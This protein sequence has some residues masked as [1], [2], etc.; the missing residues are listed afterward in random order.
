MT[1]TRQTDTVYMLPYDPAGL[2]DDVATRS[3]GLGQAIGA[4]IVA[5]TV[6]PPTRATRGRIV[7]RT[8]APLEVSLHD[9]MAALRPFVRSPDSP[10]TEADIV[11]VIPPGGSVAVPVEREKTYYDTGIYQAHPV[12]DLPPGG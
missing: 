7:A 1:V 8:T 2:A 12:V 6:E 9:L 5:M 4:G 11:V 10:Y 3:P